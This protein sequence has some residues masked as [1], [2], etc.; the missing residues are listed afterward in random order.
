MR[1]PTDVWPSLSVCMS[2]CS[3]QS[4]ENRCMERCTRTPCPRRHPCTKRCSDDCGN[5]QFPIYGVKL[6][7]GHIKDRVPCYMMETLASVKCEEPVRKQLLRCEHSA[8]IQCFKD[9]GTVSCS[10]PCG[11]ALSCCSKTCKSACSDCQK[12]AL[13][14]SAVNPAAKIVRTQHK[15][16]PCDRPL[17]CQHPCGLDCSQDHH[18]NSKCK[19]ACRQ[20][21]IHHK[22]PKSCSEPCAPCME[23]CPWS[24][25]HQSCPVACGSICSRLPCDEPCRNQLSC[26]HPCP[27]V[28]GEPCAK[29]TCIRRLDQVDLSSSDTSERLITLACGHIFTVETLDGHCDMHSYYEIDP[30]GRFISTKAPPVNYQSPP[31]CPTCRGSITA[32]RYGRVSKRAT[33]DILEQNVA[34]KMSIHSTISRL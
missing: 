34:S 1:I 22:C 33:L 6:P 4:F 12:L 11:G 29:Q 21:C 17:Y 18:C 7:C 24:C 25:A 8:T 15:P 26:G 2:C 30:M 19:Q 20:E 27:S 5:C 3:R 31:T 14:A 10:K 23:P 32:L 9:P 13:G 28:C 16:H